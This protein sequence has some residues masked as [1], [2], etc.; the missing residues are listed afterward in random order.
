LLV[1]VLTVVPVEQF[2]Q[3]RTRLARAR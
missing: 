1:F 2:R 3:L